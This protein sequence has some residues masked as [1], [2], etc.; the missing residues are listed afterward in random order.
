MR[1][2]LERRRI[3]S[4]GRFA[5]TSLLALT[6]AGATACSGI[7]DATNEDAVTGDQITGVTVQPALISGVAHNFARAYDFL[8]TNVGLIADELVTTGTWGDYTQTDQQGLFN[9]A[10]QNVNTGSV[11]ESHWNTFQA[12]RAL[13]ERAYTSIKGTSGTASGA[14]AAQARLYSGMSYLFLGELSCDVAFDGGPAQAPV[15]ALKLAETHLTEAITLADGA[16]QTRFS[17]LA[18]LMRARARFAQNNTAGAVADAQLVPAAF[19]FTVNP[20]VTGGFGWFWVHVNTFPTATVGPA[21][22]STGDPR[23]MI[24]SRPGQ[25]GQTLYIPQRYPNGDSPLVLG[26]WQEARLIEAEVALAAG[27]VATAIA[28]INEVRTAARLAPLATSL[29]SA[30]V[31]EALKLE[32][33]A[34][35]FLMGRRLQDMQRFGET[36]PEYRGTAPFARICIPVPQTER[37][38]NPTL[39][40]VRETR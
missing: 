30:Q 23:V 6:L 22:R 19:V 5:C 35:L 26:N 11:V 13:A 33:R 16:N 9:L 10:G 28:R 24:V 14:L 37:D 39:G 18:R 32:R 8:I 38:N 2:H 15:E 36:P 1:Q 17:Q 3:V 27:N 40:A 4:G 12:A 20:E 25:A 21:F 29:T 34:E 7:F 31:L